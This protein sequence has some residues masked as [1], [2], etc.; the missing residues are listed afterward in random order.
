MGEPI[1]SKPT[2][3]SHGLRK[4]VRNKLCEL[5]ELFIW[6]TIVTAIKVDEKHQELAV[7]TA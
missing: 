3:I 6:T 1:L 2:L 7:V 4:A 5:V